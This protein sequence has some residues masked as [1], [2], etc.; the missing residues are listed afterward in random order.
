[1]PILVLQPWPTQ[2][3]SGSELVRGIVEF[4]EAEG[5]PLPAPECGVGEGRSREGTTSEGPY[6]LLG[7]Y[8]L[9]WGL[10]GFLGSGMGRLEFCGCAMPS[11]WP[12]SQNE[13]LGGFQLD[14]KPA[15]ARSTQIS[16]LIQL[17]SPLRVYIWVAKEGR[18]R[19]GDTFQFPKPRS[20]QDSGW[21]A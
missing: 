9:R 16:H 2:L 1:M 8:C 5:I 7:T 12:L 3:T 15:V 18:G 11:L 10:A 13:G 14:H 4:R 6:H 17:P 21:G 19:R 20:V